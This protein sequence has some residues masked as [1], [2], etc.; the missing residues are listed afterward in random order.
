VNQPL[1]PP[2]GTDEPAGAAADP[3]GEPRPIDDLVDWAIEAEIETSHEATEPE[4]ERGLIRRSARIVAGF[5]L[6]IVGIFLL[7]LPG[8]GLIT[9]AAGLALLSRDV[10]FARRWL[11]IVRRRIPESEDGEVAGW[12][13]VLSVVLLV[14]SLGG[15]LAWVLLH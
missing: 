10:P 14:A 15:S 11:A 2:P 6:V 1:I 4:A 7:V 12:V 5:C 3:R 9:I 8:P 13:I